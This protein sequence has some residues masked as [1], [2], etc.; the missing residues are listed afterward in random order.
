MNKATTEALVQSAQ[1]VPEPNGFDSPEESDVRPD[2]NHL[3]ILR[4]KI[5]EATR[6]LNTRYA[7]AHA[8]KTFQKWCTECGKTAIPADPET[9]ELYLVSMMDRGLKVSTVEARFCAIM[10][11]HRRAGLDTGTPFNES[12]E[13][14]SGARR[15]YGKCPKQKRALTV[16]QLRE[17]SLILSKSKKLYAVRSRALLVFGFASALRRSELVSLNLS[18]VTFT[19]N[20]LVVYIRKSKTDQEQKGR[21]I[22]IFPGQDEASCPIK[23]LQAW[24]ECRGNWEGPLFC[25]LSSGGRKVANKVSHKLL[26][27]DVPALLVKD[28]VR[29]IGLDP[30]AYGA[31]SLRAGF[32][33][34]AAQAGASEMQIMQR[35]GHKSME[36]VMRYVRPSSLFWANPL[37]KAL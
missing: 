30:A 16:Q 8:W 5:F 10:Y 25:G 32:V 26:R 35:T 23:A 24:L 15:F 7:Y 20:G 12:R 21:S 2:L 1:A 37:A 4:S 18:D 31:H 27:C 22:G 9:I 36:M 34:A 11:A 33:T 28:A 13:L 17:I 29:M 6:A 14:L 19:E 3:R